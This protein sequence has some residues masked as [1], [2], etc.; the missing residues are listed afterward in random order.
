MQQMSLVV[1]HIFWEGNGTA[2]KLAS[3]ASDDFIWWD[4]SPVWLRPFLARDLHQ[5]FFRFS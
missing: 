5:E 2:D 4:S 3:L 1:S